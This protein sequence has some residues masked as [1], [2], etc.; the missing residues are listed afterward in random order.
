M[1]GESIAVFYSTT[2]PVKDREKVLKSELNEDNVLVFARYK[3]FAQ[4][5]SSSNPTIIIA[6]SSFEITNPEYV[7]VL[8]FQNSSKSDFKYVFLSSKESLGPSKVESVNVGLVEELDRQKIIE[9]FKNQVGIAL[10]KIKTVSKPEDLFPLIVFNSVDMIVTSSENHEELRKRFTA[11]VHPVN[12][13]SKD[14]SYPQVYVKKTN[15]DNSLIEKILNIKPDQVKK[16][17]FDGV[18]RIVK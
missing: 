11:K 1:S 17:G 4:T 18:V 2:V 5:V 6:P 13:K 16:L 3:D 8:Q 12:V 15:P 7:P 14:V 10:Q 9:Y